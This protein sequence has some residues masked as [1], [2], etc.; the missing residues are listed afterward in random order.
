M[1]WQ[2]NKTLDRVYSYGPQNRNSW[3]YVTGA[4]WKLLQMDHDCQSEAMTMMAAHARCDK[5]KV[6]LLE[7]GGNIQAMYVW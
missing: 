1:A 7:D 2:Y 4:G 6:D 3:I 5:R